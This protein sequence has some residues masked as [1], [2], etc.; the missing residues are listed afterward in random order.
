M[1]KK[2]KKTT[3]CEHCGGERLVEASVCQTCN[4]DVQKG[5]YI[6]YDCK[7]V[8]NAIGGDP[9]QKVKYYEH[10]PRCQECDKK[11]LKGCLWITVGFFCVAGLGISQCSSTPSQHRPSSPPTPS[12]YSDDHGYS[13]A[14]DTQRNRCYELS[15]R[16][17]E[18]KRL[19][20]DDYGECWKRLKKICFDKHG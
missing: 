8:K 16:L 17:C 7:E 6:C 4:R 10:G 2:I 14:F 20:G 3:E 9:A 11:A 18:E 15:R 1:T 12:R 13:D 19:Q 5:R